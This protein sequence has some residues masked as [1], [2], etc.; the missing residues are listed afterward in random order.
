MDSLWGV[1]GSEL[2][3]WESMTLLLLQDYGEESEQSSYCKKS[4]YALTIQN[5][6]N[7]YWIIRSVQRGRRGSDRS[8]D[9]HHQTGSPGCATCRAKSW[10]EGVD[11]PTAY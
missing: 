8:D 4:D 5:G 11:R 9:M 7:N 3:D 2:R 1:A 6:H 10:K